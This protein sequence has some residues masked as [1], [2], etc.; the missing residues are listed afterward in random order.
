MTH[1]RHPEGCGDFDWGK[2]DGVLLNFVDLYIFL[3]EY[4]TI[5]R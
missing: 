5:E 3:M 1:L 4:I 2:D